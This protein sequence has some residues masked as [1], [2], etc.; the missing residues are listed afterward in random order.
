MGSLQ[1]KKTHVVFFPVLPENE[2][3]AALLPPSLLSGMLLPLK[4]LVRAASPWG[5]AADTDVCILGLGKFIVC[6]SG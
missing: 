2:L 5:C 3:A 4:G 1:L 6:V